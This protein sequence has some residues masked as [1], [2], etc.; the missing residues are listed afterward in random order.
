M[1]TTTTS[2]TTDTAKITAARLHLLMLLEL[3]LLLL[4]RRI[5][6]ATLAPAAAATPAS[7]TPPPPTAAG[8]AAAPLTTT[9]SCRPVRSGLASGADSLRI[10]LLPLLGFV[11]ASLRRRGRIQ[12]RFAAL[13]VPSL[14]IAAFRFV[15]LR[16]DVQLSRLP[17]RLRLRL[18]SQ[19][20][21]N[22]SASLRLGWLRL[23]GFAAPL[24][25]CSARPPLVVRGAAPAAAAVRRSGPG[26]PVEPVLREKP[27]GAEGG[28]PQFPR[29]RC[30]RGGLPQQDK[31]QRP[32]GPRA[33]CFCG[34]GH[35]SH[36]CAWK[37]WD[38]R[39]DAS[40]PGA[41]VPS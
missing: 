22:R 27:R 26:E 39:C 17:V 35:P 32:L 11:S 8:A 28:W 7:T 3:P 13:G 40:F 12:V 37:R 16:F 33:F 19:I 41:T 1:N 30:F 23:P 34:P 6:T 18:Q 15:S 2:T 31:N 21:S 9:T 29:G 38:R 20:D 10:R 25:Y 14:C 24:H 4:P 5:P 36:E